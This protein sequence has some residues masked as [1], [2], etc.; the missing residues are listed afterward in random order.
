MYGHMTVAGFWNLEDAGRRLHDS[1][2]EDFCL[3]EGHLYPRGK[4]LAVNSVLKLVRL[5]GALP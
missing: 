4:D 1:L 3:L 2:V 5:Y